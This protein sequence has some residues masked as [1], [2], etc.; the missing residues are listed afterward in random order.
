MHQFG[1]KYYATIVYYVKQINPTQIK[2]K[3]QKKKTLKD[4][5]YISIIES[6]LT[7]NDQFHHPQKE[8]H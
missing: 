3:L 7:Q 8:T 4:K 1:L 6:H 2:N 5:I